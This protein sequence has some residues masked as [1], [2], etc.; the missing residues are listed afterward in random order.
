M[1]SSAR[2]LYQITAFSLAANSS[3]PGDTAY[4]SGC[5][6][7]II[8]AATC[9]QETR[10]HT[11]GTAQLD[12]ASL[13]FRGWRSVCGKRLQPY[14]GYR[15]QNAT[16]FS[17][18][19]QHPWVICHC[20]PLHLLGNGLDARKVKLAEDIR[21]SQSHTPI[22]KHRICWFWDLYKCQAQTN[23]GYLMLKDNEV[24]CSLEK[25]ELK[26]SK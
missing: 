21:G 14:V 19:E 3:S 15:V 13:P 17:T 10:L 7:S 1:L 5:W 12:R 6:F 2:I 20:A 25:R 24:G 26:P 22:L 8:W 23:T 4:S 18:H 16:L 9:Y 11:P